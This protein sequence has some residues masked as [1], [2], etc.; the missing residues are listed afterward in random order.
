MPFYL[1]MSKN[2]NET[3]RHLNVSSFHFI[4]TYINIC[5]IEI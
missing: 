2:I 5:E 1:K 4:Y 3:T